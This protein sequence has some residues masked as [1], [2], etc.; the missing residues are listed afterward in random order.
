MV[1]NRILASIWSSVRGMADF[2]WFDDRGIYLIS[3]VW[4]PGMVCNSLFRKMCVHWLV[5]GKWHLHYKFTRIFRQI[6]L[7]ERSQSQIEKRVQQSLYDPSFVVC[8][9][10]RLYLYHD[11]RIW[12]FTVIIYLAFSVCMIESIREASRY[13]F[14]VCYC[15]DIAQE[16]KSLATLYLHWQIA[17]CSGFDSVIIPVIKVL[18]WFEKSE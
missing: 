3:I 14:L 6:T 7:T 18:P 5:G 4:N 12:A 16:N 15:S 10:S 2:D 11:V 9:W 13:L 1:Q 8:D 17:I